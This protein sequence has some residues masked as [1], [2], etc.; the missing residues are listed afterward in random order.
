MKCKLGRL[1]EVVKSE[2]IRRE[3]VIEGSISIKVYTKN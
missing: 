1:K 3:P 2:R